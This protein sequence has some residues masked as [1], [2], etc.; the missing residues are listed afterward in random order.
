MNLLRLFGFKKE[1]CHPVVVDQEFFNSVGRSIER[2][3]KEFELGALCRIAVDKAANRD[4]LI[5]SIK[6]A[7][8][9]V[10]IQVNDE[11]Y[12][13]IIHGFEMRNVWRIAHCRDK[14]RRRKA[15]LR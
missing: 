13:T 8:D 14:I 9:K 7:E 12:Q 5:A 10:G 1:R 4:D 3:S 2:N 6:S 15:M 11:F